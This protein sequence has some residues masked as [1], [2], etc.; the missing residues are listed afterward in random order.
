[1]ISE[2]LTNSLIPLMETIHRVPRHPRQGVPLH[3]IKC[4]KERCFPSMSFG[5]AQVCYVT[6]FYLVLVQGQLLMK[7]MVIWTCF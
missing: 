4:R 1:M 2:L 3:Y 5:N 7:K 6:A